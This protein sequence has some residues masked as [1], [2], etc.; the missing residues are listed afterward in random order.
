VTISDSKGINDNIQEFYTTNTAI[1]SPNIGS[2]DISDNE[3]KDTYNVKT[4][5]ERV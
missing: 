1:A 3:A 2:E 5:T 4:K